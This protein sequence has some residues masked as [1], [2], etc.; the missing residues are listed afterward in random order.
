MKTPVRTW[1]ASIRQ[2]MKYNARVAAPKMS[3]VCADRLRLISRVPRG[4]VRVLSTLSTRV[5]Y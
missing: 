5:E 4:A 1:P 2:V 3:P